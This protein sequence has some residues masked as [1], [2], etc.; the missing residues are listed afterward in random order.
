MRKLILIIILTL[1]SCSVEERI[2]EHSYTEEWYIEQGVEY[3]V[4]K[5]KNNRKYIIVLNKKETNFKRKYIN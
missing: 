1:T 3:Q 2:K 4:Y 5:T